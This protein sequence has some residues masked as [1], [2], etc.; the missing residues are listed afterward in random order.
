MI[1]RTIKNNNNI[2]NSNDNNDNI[3]NNNSNNKALSKIFHIPVSANAIGL[4]VCYCKQTF[5]ENVEKSVE[6][7]SMTSLKAYIS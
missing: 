3:T 2:N 1:I 5:S 6:K 7:I 4:Q